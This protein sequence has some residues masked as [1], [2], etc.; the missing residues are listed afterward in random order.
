MLVMRSKGSPPLFAERFPLIAIAVG[1]SLANSIAL[2][3]NIRR[4][5][6]GMDVG[7]LD[8]DFAREWWWW[9]MPQFFTPNLLWIGGSLAFAGVT[10]IVIYH[11]PRKESLAFVANQPVN[12]GTIR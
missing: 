10:W 6:T 9:F 11:L 12:T 3:T 2:H 4:Y 5:V 1:L 7:G 8:L